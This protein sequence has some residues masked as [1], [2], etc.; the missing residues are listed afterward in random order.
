MLYRR[1][2]AY[3]GHTVTTT[4]IQLETRHDDESTIKAKSHY[5]QRAGK[6]TAEV[7]RLRMRTFA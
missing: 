4:A 6:W 3:S 1:R 7:D 2:V 5:R